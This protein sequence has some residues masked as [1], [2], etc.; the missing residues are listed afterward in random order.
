MDDFVCPGRCFQT[1]GSLGKRKMDYNVRTS[2]KKGMNTVPK[3]LSLSSPRISEVL[4]LFL[5]FAILNKYGFFFCKDTC[6]YSPNTIT[7][8]TG[9]RDAVGPN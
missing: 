1:K 3:V 5:P 7:Q 6:A 4:I 9:R 8:P 2:C